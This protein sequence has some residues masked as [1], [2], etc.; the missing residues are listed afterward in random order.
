MQIG[1]TYMA[2]ISFRLRG[3]VCEIAVGLHK[4]QEFYK[5]SDMQVWDSNPHLI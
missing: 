1:M 3:I 2:T 4:K 5:R